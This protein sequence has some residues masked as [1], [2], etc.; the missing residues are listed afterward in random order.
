MS[1]SSPTRPSAPGARGSKAAGGGSNRLPSSRERR[2][3]LAALA[4]ILILLGAS[5]S[6]L[7]AL[8]SGNRQDYIVM[9]PTSLPP[10]SRIDE[11]DFARGDLAGKTGA[12]IPYAQWKKYEGQYTTTW[13][14]RNQFVTPQNFTTEPIPAGGALVGVS[15]EAGRAPSSNLAGGDIVQVVQVPASNQAGGVPSILVTAASVTS[16]SGKVTDDKTSA[17]TTLNVTILVPAA[18]STAV[19][20]A[21]A[22][23]TLVLVKLPAGTKPDVAPIRAGG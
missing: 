21:A 3:A 10:G 2:P 20:A 1:F 11:D 9:V 19:A 18:Q 5:G 12:L 14:Y 13:L 17:S 22:S 8:R 23:K 6:A 16:S 15:L 4:V 7:I